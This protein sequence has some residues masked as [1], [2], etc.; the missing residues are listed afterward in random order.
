[1]LWEHLHRIWHEIPCA[2]NVLVLVLGKVFDNH[3]N[4]Q[5]LAQN[6]KLINERSAFHLSFSLDHFRF[7][8]NLCRLVSWNR[9]LLYE[10]CLSQRFWG[11]RYDIYSERY[12]S[13]M[14]MIHKQK[15]KL[16]LFVLVSLLVIFSSPRFRQRNET[17]AGYL[18]RL[19]AY[20][21][22]LVFSEKNG[23]IF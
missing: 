18:S 15:I 6:T 12:N 11:L 4:T 21:I 14:G 20:T 5:N 22:P 8:R 16:L 9:M 10:L 3:K 2:Q 17:G 19:R 23:A 7:I 13:L 1:M